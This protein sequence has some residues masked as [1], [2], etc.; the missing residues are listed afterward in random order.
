MTRNVVREGRGTRTS[1]LSLLCGRTSREIAHFGDVVWRR[2]RLRV[3]GIRESDGSYG[4]G[5]I[6]K[7]DEDAE[8]TYGQGINLKGDV[9]GVNTAIS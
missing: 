6:V 3:K 1:Q 7:R 4:T 9:I 5:G 2:V 8:D